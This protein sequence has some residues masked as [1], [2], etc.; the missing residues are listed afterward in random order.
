MVERIL[1]R[2]IFSH[3]IQQSAKYVVS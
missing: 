2:I 1:D 3:Q